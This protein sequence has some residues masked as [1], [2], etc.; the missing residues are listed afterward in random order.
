MAFALK[1]NCMVGFLYLPN[2]SAGACRGEELLVQLTYYYQL[3]S[4]H[5]GS[6]PGSVASELI[7]C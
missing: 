4:H 1:I 5:G 2:K 6:L 7:C 3:R